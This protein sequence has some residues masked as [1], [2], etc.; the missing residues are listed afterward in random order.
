MKS[1][2]DQISNLEKDLSESNKE[3]SNIQMTLLNERN[4]HELRI[5]ELKSKLNEVCFGGKIN[6]NKLQFNF[7]LKNSFRNVK[8]VN[9]SKKN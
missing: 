2:L 3:L 1:L 9:L 7:F 8:H 4:I 5:L 6:N